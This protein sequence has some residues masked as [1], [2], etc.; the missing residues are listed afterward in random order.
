MSWR[1]ALM[2]GTVIVVVGLGMLTAA[3]FLI[4]NLMFG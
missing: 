1:A 2:W 3:Y 4:Q